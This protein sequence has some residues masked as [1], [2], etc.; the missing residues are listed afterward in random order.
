MNRIYTVDI[1][2][3]RDRAVY[4]YWYNQMPPGRR[5]KID[6]YKPKQSK[7]LSLAAGIALKKAFE[8]AGLATCEVYEN[9]YGKPYIKG[10][11]DV[12]FNLS[13]SGDKAIAVISDAEVGIDIQKI[14]HF[15]ENLIERVFTGSE[16]EQVGQIEGDRD[17]CFT[18]LWTAKESIMKY[19]GKGLSMDPLK[20]NIQIKSIDNLDTEGGLRLFR[21]ELD[22]YQVTICT[23]ETDFSEVSI[24]DVFNEK[25]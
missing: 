10:A 7:L 6:R 21:K 24:T 14:S 17:I 4:E 23:S 18:A 22:G 9:D 2:S 12:F 20:I 25:G 15:K 11:M 13:H 1:N 3:I 19:Y 8:A 16:I 5:E